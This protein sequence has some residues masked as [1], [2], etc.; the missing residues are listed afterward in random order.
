MYIMFFNTIQDK[1]P[2][3]KFI[4]TPLVAEDMQENK[5]HKKAPLNWAQIQL[6][7]L[8]VKMSFLF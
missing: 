8:V 4:L 3:A 1:W 2:N 7:N 6:F 5:A